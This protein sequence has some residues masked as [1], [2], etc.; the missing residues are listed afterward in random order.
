MQNDLNTCTDIKQFVNCYNCGCL[1]LFWAAPSTYLYIM[2]SQGSYTSYKNDIR[3]IEMWSTWYL[4]GLGFTSVMCCMGRWD[5]LPSLWD[6]PDKRWSVVNHLSFASQVEL[7][8]TGNVDLRHQLDFDARQFVALLQLL[9]PWVL[10]LGYVD[11]IGKSN[12]SSIGMGCHSLWMLPNRTSPL[13]C[14]RYMARS[15]HLGMICRFL[16]HSEWVW[17]IMIH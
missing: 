5:M 8:S 2:S 3:M 11:T 17:Y 10:G 4:G 9:G 13:V 12:R 16:R 1:E 14:W 6:R 7:F 15:R